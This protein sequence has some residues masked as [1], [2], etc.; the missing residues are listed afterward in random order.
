MDQ[1]K[2]GKFIAEIRKKQ[3][4]TQEQLAEKLG[5][6]DRAISNWENGK[7]MPDLSMF[8]LLCDELNISINELMSGEELDESRY[9]KK[10]EENIIIMVNNIEAKKKRRFKWSSIIL[11]IVAIFG[12]CFYNFHLIDIKYDSRISGCDIEN[13]ILHIYV[14]G[15]SVWNTDIIKKEIDNEDIYLVHST[16][17]IYNK[18]RSNLEYSQTMANLLEGKEITFQGFHKLEIGNKKVKVYY[19]D[20]R[21]NKLKRIKDKDKI[22]EIISNSYLMC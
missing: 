17:N 6:T 10:L 14:K 4:M 20:E 22:K 16:I 13:D 18:R 1:E 9:I 5:V 19:T 8:K 3:K 12:W 11:L 2:I 7:N 21:I 15:Q